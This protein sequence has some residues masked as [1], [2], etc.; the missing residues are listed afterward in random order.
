MQGE[1]PF[2]TVDSLDQLHIFIFVMAVVHVV[3]SCLTMLLAM[4]KVWEKNSSHNKVQGNWENSSK[5]FRV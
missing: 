1:E 2:V 5:G 4:V 3:Y